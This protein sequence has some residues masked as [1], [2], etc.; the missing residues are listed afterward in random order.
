LFVLLV[1]IGGF[2]LLGGVFV[3]L[4]VKLWFI[5]IPLLIVGLFWSWWTR[6]RAG[7]GWTGPR[8]DGGNTTTGNPGPGGVIETEYRVEKDDD[9][10]SK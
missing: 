2:L 5:W 8:D 1:V 3:V 6:L 10:R 4:L 7:R 9:S